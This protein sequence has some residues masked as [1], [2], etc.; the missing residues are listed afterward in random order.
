MKLMRPFVAVLMA[1]A[2]LVTTQQ[3]AAARGQAPAVGEAV[4]CI[5]GQAV[6]VALDANGQPV[7]QGAAAH[8]CPDCILHFTDTQHP[9]ATGAVDL[10]LRPFRFGGD[11]ATLAAPVVA[12]CPSARGPPVFV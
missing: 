1:L 7:E 4:L 12:P 9:P 10:T 6:T 11:V 5:G 8:F 3:M 2:L